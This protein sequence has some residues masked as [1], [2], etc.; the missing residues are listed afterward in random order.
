MELQ[1]G[2]RT[3]YLNWRQVVETLPYIRPTW[4]PISYY[5]EGGWLER[6]K[7]LPGSIR[8]VLRS[9]QEVRD[10]LG[11]GKYDAVLFNTHNPAVTYPRAVQDN[12]TF[13]MFDVTPK[14]YDTMVDIYG[15]GQKADKPGPLAEYKHRRVCETFRAAEGLF[16]WSRWAAQSAIED[17][18][19]DPE[20]VHILPPGVDTQRWH[21]A[22][23]GMRPNDGIT[24]ILFTGGN[25]ERKGGAMMLRWARE[26]TRKNWEM[27]LVTIDKVKAPPGVIV[28]NNVGSN[29]QELI[30][31]A[32]RCD[33]F[34][35]PTR[36]DCFSIASLEA[37]AAGL[38]VIVTDVGGI[39][40]IVRDG[41]TG[42][43]IP[44]EDYDALRDRLEFLLD[45]PDLRAKMGQRGRQI[46]CAQFDVREQ[47]LRGL[48]VMAR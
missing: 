25:F 48:E 31:L 37:M 11:Q 6:I 28:H 35:L 13:L 21:P 20:R 38:P 36:A 2:M 44:R 23:E 39:A 9:R 15:F 18:G 30:E 7:F 5:R 17:Y 8:S 33:L 14:Q 47:V 43:L 4:V 40:D 1:A 24:R 12:R 10:G 16:P 32:Q 29:A 42:Y 22:P 46:V 3:Q 45:A 26:T 27:H 41:E 34:V 19:A